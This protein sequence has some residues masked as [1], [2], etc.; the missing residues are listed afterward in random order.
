MWCG[1]VEEPGSSWESR[2]KSNKFQPFSPLQVHTAA[3]FL[4]STMRDNPDWARPISPPSRRRNQG[5]RSTARAQFFPSEVGVTFRR[6]WGAVKRRDW[7]QCCCHPSIHSPPVTGVAPRHA[8]IS[9]VILGFALKTSSVV[10]R[11]PFF[12]QVH[13]FV[14]RPQLA[15]PFSCVWYACLCAES[16]TSAAAG[17]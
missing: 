6:T 12:L 17:R 8:C 16:P 5:R 10:S 4:G 7:L 15:W 14:P 13:V 3:S 2:A 9:L 1:G 11:S